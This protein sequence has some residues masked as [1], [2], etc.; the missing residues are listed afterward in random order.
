MQDS[1][2]I[3]L[4]QD[5]PDALVRQGLSAYREGSIAK[6]RYFFR[7]VLQN[8]TSESLAYR[9]ARKLTEFEEQFL[10][11]TYEGRAFYLLMPK[12]R[13]P[14]LVV[15]RPSFQEWETLNFLRQYSNDH[16]NIL[17]VGC[18]IGN[19]SLFFYHFLNSRNIFGFDPAPNAGF[20][21]CQNVPQAK[22]FNLA[23]GAQDQSVDLA[24]DI[25][26]GRWS[27]SKIMPGSP[28]REDLKKITTRSLDSFEFRDVTL[29]KIDVESW[30]IPVLE[31]GMQTIK[32]DRPLI[33]IEFLPQNR[34]KY[35]AFFAQHLPEYK[36]VF[37]VEA[38]TTGR[39]DLVFRAD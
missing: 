13:L 7:R 20:F 38:P 17:D 26:N 18:N 16:K 6:S 23:L 25:L 9:T 12:G 3:A 34:E 15:K 19:H 10:E 30:E 8:A 32:R 14:G 4:A 31:G 2:N 28:I 35:A 21:Y 37:S 11:I 1:D 29:L 24:G 33:V 22:F 5:D 27:Q 39:Q 36:I